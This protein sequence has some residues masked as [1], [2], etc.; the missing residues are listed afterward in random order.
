MTI[1]F[2]RHGRTIANEKHIYCGSSD[3][4]L[5]ET[6]IREIRAQR[7]RYPQAPAALYTSGM[8][9][10]EQTFECIYGDL[11][12]EILPAFREIDFGIFEMRS[13]DELKDEPTY[14]AWITGDNHRNLC[15]GG[16]SGAIMQ[17]R[18]MAAFRALCER[19][20]DALV[21]THGG[22]IAAIMAE[23]F[24]AEGKNRFD[25]QPAPAH[26]YAITFSPTP[27]YTSIPE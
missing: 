26:G 19:N 17:E 14:Q 5:L 27:R 9:R 16:E 1:Y 3:I 12:H 4:P 11:P 23:L 8:L 7:S 15:P 2:I 22:V 24:P 21:V 25:W 20:E 10:T 13:Y 6:S 18:V